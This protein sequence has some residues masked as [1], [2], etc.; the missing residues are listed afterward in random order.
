MQREFYRDKN[1]IYENR[2]SRATGKT[3]KHA[4]GL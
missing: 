3:F 1:E 2:S 4:N